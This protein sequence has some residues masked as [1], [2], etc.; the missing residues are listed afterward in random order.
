MELCRRNNKCTAIGSPALE[1][2][3]A[4][5]KLSLRRLSLER[6]LK[7]VRLERQCDNQDQEKLVKSYNDRMAAIT[8]RFRSIMNG[9]S[10]TRREYRRIAKDH[11][12]KNCG[13]Y[14]VRKHTQLLH[15]MR[16]QQ[17]LESYVSI[18]QQ[19]CVKL[20][21]VMQETHHDML[22]DLRVKKSQHN[23]QKH[24]IEKQLVA[25][26]TAKVI[27]YC[28]FNDTNSLTTKLRHPQQKERISLALGTRL[29]KKKS[30]EHRFVL[31]GVVSRRDSC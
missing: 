22:Y 3:I 23:V 18:S 6:Q 26:V 30:R 14:V 29:M 7:E 20:I 4:A 2:Q 27:S 21:E 13:D 25:I 17:L 12:S 8:K 11:Y 5:G 9:T 31:T 19:Q 15:L 16:S 10:D 28:K 24:Q 1:E